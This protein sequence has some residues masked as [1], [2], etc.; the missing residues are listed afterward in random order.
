MGQSHLEAS[1]LKKEVGS[2]LGVC[3]LLPLPFIS[4]L[5][6]GRAPFQ[7]KGDALTEA[8]PYQKSR[9]GRRGCLGSSQS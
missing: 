5:D 9:E 1:M 8:G 6:C 3:F 4:S 7:K 2:V